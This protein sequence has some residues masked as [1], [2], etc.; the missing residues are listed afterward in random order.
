MASQTADATEKG[1]PLARYQQS[2]ATVNSLLKQGKSWSGHERH[3]AYLN[4]GGKGR[5]VDISAVSG[6]HYADDGRGM[7][8]TDWD[9]DGDLDLW[10]TNRTAP[11]VRF[12]RNDVSRQDNEH[13]IAFRLVGE[14]CARDAIGA[15]VTVR[16]SSDPKPRV[17]TLR[18]GDGFISQSSKWMH[19]GLK[20]HRDV[21]RV[22][23]LWPGGQT[24]V[25][26]GVGA[27][28]RFILRQG[29]GAAT[30]VPSRNPL[31][32]NRARAE[33]EPEQE[34]SGIRLVSYSRP[35]FP[36]Q[37][38]TDFGGKAF[39]LGEPGNRL[40]LVN[41]WGSWCPACRREL[42]GLVKAERELTEAGIDVVGVC[43]D[44]VSENSAL[45][46]GGSAR[47]LA[48]RLKLPFDLV[49]ADDSTL[50]SCEAVQRTLLEDQSALPLPTS[51]LLDE[52][53]RVVVIYRGEVAVAQVLADAALARLPAPRWLSAASPLPGRRG[54]T[55]NPIDPIQ[56]ALKMYEGEYSKETRGYVRQLIEIVEGKREGHEVSD[57][58]GLHYFMGTL[59]EDAGNPERAL[60][61]Y[62]F[63]LKV[64]PGH[65]N[66]NRNLGRAY[67]RSRD[68]SK[69]IDHFQAAVRSEPRNLALQL[70]FA[71]LLYESADMPR[72]VAVLE[73][74]LKLDRS[75]LKGVRL[76][77]WIRSTSSDAQARDGES[78]VEL[79]EYLGG[80]T[81][82]GDVLS[83]DIL[84]AAYAE[85][86]RFTEA[87]RAAQRAIALGESVGVPA[88]RMERL[89]E[90]LRRYQ[91]RKPWRESWD[92]QR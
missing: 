85:A 69:A 22:S 13:W 26:E 32:W 82:P 90:R 52:H 77:A 91:S 71:Q 9:G 14:H 18:A 25:F 11:A 16:V 2:W 56:V 55:P 51:F 75:H 66:A 43:V 48:H 72:A 36:L 68:W 17:Q 63:V 33:T 86:G 58:V 4:T 45:A 84:G 83:Q 1:E 47:S 70:E 87:T 60:M 46:D 54:M 73:G 37:T 61:A 74:L 21:S 27:G 38:L 28:K 41:L 53:G 15:R 8:A 44:A 20:G 80:L 59:L 12:L 40:R 92:L 29:T 88:P 78:A 57:R 39:L 24:E 65:S 62:R 89:L 79:A 7:A 50:N 34:A 81:G 30:A 19:F 42:T 31:D 5:M 49:W 67:R 10:L 64:D 76:L 23:V 35:P 3:C 6:L